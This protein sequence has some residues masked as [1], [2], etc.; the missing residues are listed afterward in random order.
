MPSPRRTRTSAR[1]RWPGPGCFS[2]GNLASWSGWARPRSMARA[3]GLDRDMTALS[4]VIPAYNEEAGIAEIAR[5]VLSTR[6]ALRGVGIGQLELLV[7]DDGSRDQT[8]Q[9]ASQ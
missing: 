7:V 4:I 8:A 5:R 2:S 9:D 1:H 3:T 6:E